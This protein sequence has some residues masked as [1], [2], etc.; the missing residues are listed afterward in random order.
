MWGKINVC[1]AF[2]APLELLKNYLPLSTNLRVK[3][4]LFEF[5]TAE[6]AKQLE[7]FEMR[8]SLTLR[9]PIV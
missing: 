9:R 7:L 3:V 5:V 6:E 8:F 2:I 1:C 4:Y